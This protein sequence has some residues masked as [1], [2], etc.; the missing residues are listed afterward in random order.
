MTDSQ[1]LFSSAKCVVMNPFSTN[2]PVLIINRH[3]LGNTFIVT[4]MGESM[5]IVTAPEDVKMIYKMPKLLDLNPFIKESL[6]T[7]EICQQTIQRMFQE[8]DRGSNTWMGVTH[9]NFKAQLHPGDKLNTL[10]IDLLERV[11]NYVN[12]ER[13]NDSVIIPELSSYEEKVVPLYRWC[14]QVMIEATSRAIFDDALWNIDSEFLSHFIVSETEGWKRQL[15]FPKFAARG[16]YSSK[17]HL[18]KVFV[19]Y[20]LLPKTQRA[21]ESW[22][23]SRLDESLRDLDIGLVDRAQ[24]M[25]SFFQL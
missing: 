10:Q 7:W 11:N 1:K 24:V 3:S 17:R 13:I 2:S 14:Q 22:I 23:V 6:A 12:F 18:D 19:K 20:L 16:F 5:Y 15:Q 8:T 9:D 25:L 4:T 21:N